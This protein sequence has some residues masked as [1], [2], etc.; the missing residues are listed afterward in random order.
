MKRGISRSKRALLIF[1]STLLLVVTVLLA[2]FF[3][4]D[5]TMRVRYGNDTKEYFIPFYNRDNVKYEDSELFEYL[6]RSSMEDIVRMCV[7]KNQMETNGSYDA[8]KEI[9]ITAFANRNSVVYDSSVTAVYSLEDLIKWGNKGFDMQELDAENLPFSVEKEK[10]SVLVPRY[11]TIDGK[12]LLE[13]A[14]TYDEYQF[15]VGNLIET[16]QSLFS[17]YGE[18]E[19]FKKSYGVGLT[20]MQYCI[21][22]NNNGSIVRYTNMHNID[23]KMT[24]DD[25]STD[26]IKQVKYVY[27]NP[28]KM[29]INTNFGISAPEMKNYISKY[30]YSFTDNSRIWFGFDDSYMA[31]DGFKYAKDYY[32]SKSGN[33]NGI[34]MIVAIWIT[35]FAYLSVVVFL[36]A[37]EGRVYSKKK[38]KVS[39]K[40]KDD[41][42]EIIEE[43]SV[44]EAS[45][46]IVLG[47]LD[48]MPVEFMAILAFAFAVFDIVILFSSAQYIHAN[49]FGGF[50]I[51]AV[52]VGAVLVCNFTFLL[53]LLCFVR[54]VKAK[55]LLEN[56]CCKWIAK[57]IREKTIDAYDHGHAVI[58][59]WIPYVL[60]LL[61]NLVL[62]LLSPIGMVVAVIFDIVIGICLYRA[63][64][65]RQEI[66]KSIN[67]ISN[68]DI[69]HQLDL[70]NMHGDNLE[71]GKAV[72]NIGDGIRKAVESSMKNEKM[73]ADLITNVSHDIKT[74]LTSII[75]YV[76]L[77]KR[78]NIQDEKIKGYIEILDS[79]SQRLKQLTDDLVEAS[80]ISSGNIV[81]KFEKINLVELVNQS[82]GEFEDKFAD[83]GLKCRFVS[84]E[85]PVYV[86]VD[87]R[88]M[89][90]VIENLYNNIYKYALQGTR[91]YI[92][93]D[94][95]GTEGAQRVQ[96]S[97]K[98]ISEN[99]LNMSA[100]ELLERFKQGDESRKTEGSGLGLSIAKSLTEAMNGQFDIFLDGDLFKIILTF[101][102]I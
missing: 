48:H 55:N 96:L 79:K 86:N 87:A 60:F 31:N 10:A 98:N 17:N 91:V 22:M 75:S 20:N 102:T 73:K 16:A 65:E 56:S 46:E 99:Q 68:G 95:I 6:Y 84:P 50:F 33:T 52:A 100:E 57:T 37:K 101:N 76:D 18:Y 82:I 13:C 51:Y 41:D 77:I 49:I 66:V 32:D 89:F 9:D 78:E 54:R 42:I 7:I 71:L 12:D 27:Y 80:K 21:Q 47:K 58:R 93:M 28:D 4:E 92:D 90:R 40:S 44:D 83:H 15:L 1:L 19:S 8:K 70:K 63:N 45:E 34:V 2:I 62:L 53:T 69:N 30:E 88:S 81:L 94:I 39:A 24:I 26:F 74:P 43:V 67:T 29:T 23:I 85:K 64:N 38:K 14:N 11:K 97:F 3:V 35:F 25:I 36:I 5:S 59:T 61:I 72:N